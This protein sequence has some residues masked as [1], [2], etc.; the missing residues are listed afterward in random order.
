MS[1]S[2][3]YPY[4]N[5][6]LLLSPQ[7][8]Q[9]TPFTG[10]SFLESYKKN[11]HDIINFLKNFSELDGPDLII[12]NFKNFSF[13]EIFK[14]EKI[15]TEMLLKGLSYEIIHSSNY[16]QKFIS[17]IDILLKKFEIKKKL[18]LE[19]DSDFNPISKDF[20]NITNYILLSLILE[21]LFQKFKNLKYINSV[22]KINDTIISQ[23]KYL[24][25]DLMKKLFIIVLKN[26]LDFVNKLEI[27]KG[28]TSS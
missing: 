19:Y 25:T 5:S 12:K 23:I 22:L 15:N 16:E 21:N 8:Y 14:S 7:K 11:R 13:D 6:D 28:I 18:F 2:E 10:K 3:I 4:A 1:S 26:E 24:D 9:M 20:N 17:V 27:D